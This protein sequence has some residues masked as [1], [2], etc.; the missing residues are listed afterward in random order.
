[1][2]MMVTM[3]FNSGGIDM[4]GNGGSVKTIIGGGGGGGVMKQ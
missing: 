2:I 1:M 4:K 3:M